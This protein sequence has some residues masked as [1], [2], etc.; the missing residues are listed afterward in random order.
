MLAYFDGFNS[1]ILMRR[2]RCPNCSTVFRMRPTGYLSRF[3]AP[4]ET[5]RSSIANKVIKQKWLSA[6]GRTRQQHWFRELVRKAKAFLGNTWE[7]SMVKAFDY[8]I[9]NKINPVTRSFKPVTY[10]FHIQPTE[11]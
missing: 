4:I 8:F 3:Q 7:H 9:S 1:S 10:S 11:G 6:L 2:Y 5:I